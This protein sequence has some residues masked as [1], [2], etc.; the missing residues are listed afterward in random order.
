MPVRKTVLERP[1]LVFALVLVWKI[2]LLLFSAQ[3]VPSNDAFFYDGPVVN[4]VLHGKYANPS[5]VEAL[6][7]SGGE[8]FCAYPPLYQLALFGW[9]SIFGV[10]ALVSMFFHLF[11]FAIYLW[12]L[13]KTFRQLNLTGWP[14]S[15][16]GAFLLV[17]TF[18]DRPDSLAHVFGMLAVYFWIRSRNSLY[19]GSRA[20]ITSLKSHKSFKLL[21]LPMAWQ[22]GNT[23]FTWAA[24]ACVILGLATGL[25]IG[26]LYFLLIWVGMLATAVLE[27]EP[28]PVVPMSVSAFVPIALIALVIFGFPH[29]WEGF[30][31][32]AR[33]TPS[34]TGLRVPRM[35]EILKA[36]RTVPGILLVVALLPW[37]LKVRTKL[38]AAGSGALWLVTLSCSLAAFTVVVA[39]L[40]VLTPNSVFF[41]S[42]LQPLIVGCALGMVPIICGATE[43]QLSPK[44]A[45]PPPSLSNP[46]CAKQCRWVIGLFLI[47]AAVGSIRAIGMSTWGVLC[48][49]DFSYGKAINR[50][51]T[52]LRDCSQGST[53]VLSSA[54]LYEASRQDKIRWLHSDWIAPARRGGS[55]TDL[56][57]LLKLKPC[58]IV[59]TQFDY[60]RRF[61][62]VMAELKQ[63]P[64]LAHLEIVNTTGTRTPDSLPSLQ[65][66]V[67]HI[68]WAPV[69][70]T[71]TWR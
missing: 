24:I 64:E 1:E 31:E 54:Y 49:A 6:P 65:K 61:E 57:A 32:H 34:L 48:A 70:I 44:G 52:E 55:S 21:T 35:A 56:D 28:F 45:N 40:S 69:M 68:S 16:G 2:V 9:L 51:A 58:K 11:L 12:I 3:P 5:L 42:Y 14:A 17:I 4:F 60:Y 27:K 10:S 50:I 36:L 20:G 30:L 66:V 38:Q 67:Q 26:A 62:A 39:S 29:L 15:I 22:S 23:G 59:L 53:V 41:V 33:Q 47:L 37:W 43:D 46:L 13:L 25:Q 8:V 19:V 63:R 7:I 71:L 18:H